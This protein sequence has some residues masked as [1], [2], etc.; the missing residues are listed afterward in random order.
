M[1]ANKMISYV[2]ILFSLAATSIF[3]E[4]PKPM[5]ADSLGKDLGIVYKTAFNSDEI[6]K[7][8][9][10]KGF[11]ASHITPWANLENAIETFVKAK[12]SGD[13][14]LL[15]PLAV[16][17]A[18]NYKIMTSLVEWQK[19]VQAG[20]VDPSVAKQ[21]VTMLTES[22]NKVDAASVKLKKAWFLRSAK[23]E[24]ERVLSSFGNYVARIGQA[25]IRDLNTRV[26]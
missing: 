25:L 12:A 7:A 19:F 20:K 24:A 23:V 6:A 17:K 13:N 21:T 11:V 22:V 3:A 18:E 26:K 2:S 1:S 14:D 9:L 15:A 5:T 4:A 8:G 16:F 10:L